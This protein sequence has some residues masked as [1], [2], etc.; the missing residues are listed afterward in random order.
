MSSLAVA[1]IDAGIPTGATDPGTRRLDVDAVIKDLVA[2]F[3]ATAVERDK[4]GGSAKAERD[5]L[6]ASGLLSMLIPQSEGGLG[7]SWP[8]IYRVI[9][10]F[11]AVDS[12][13]GQLFGFQNLMLATIELFGSEEQRQ[14]YFTRT[15]K[16]RW[17]WGNTLNPLDQ[18]LEARWQDGRLVLNGRKTF[19]T[20]S[21]DAEALIVSSPNPDAGRLIVAAVPLPRAGLTLHGDWDNM[22]Q[23]QTDS[24]SVTFENFIIHPGEILR[25]PGPF[26]SPRASLRPCVAQL[27]FANVYLGIAMG[28]LAEAKKYTR[29]TTRPWLTSGVASA[30]EDPYVLRHYGEMWSQ[31]QA[32]IAVTDLAAESLQCAW[33]EGNTLDDAGRGQAALSI[34]TA[35]VVTTRA[36]LD[37]VN[38]M[39]EVMGSRATAASTRL[40]RYW[41]NL[42]TYTLHDPVDYKLKELGDWALND[43]FPTPTFYS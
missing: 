34:A 37:A 3:A 26:G 8:E 38:R 28:G 13:I 11:S 4:S 15:A 10:R 32:A 41:R 5:A 16:Q 42:R 6:R 29:S 23:R 35:K 36:G 17:F 27:V 40:D 20:G 22:G 30:S 39:F 12:S 14:S 2:R 24:G 25:S 33:D 31:L 21:S 19:S 43:E 1:Q 7:C 9:R 18:G